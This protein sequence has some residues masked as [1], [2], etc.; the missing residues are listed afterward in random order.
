MLAGGVGSAVLEALNEA[1]LL[2]TCQVLTLGIPDE[3][4]LHGDKK[5]LMKDLGLDVDAIVAKTIAMV[6]EA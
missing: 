5:L 2:Q 3:F 4:V 6:K 1:K